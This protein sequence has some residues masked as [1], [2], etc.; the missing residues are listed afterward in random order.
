[1]AKYYKI[2]MLITVLSVILLVY[3]FY[4]NQQFKNN[5]LSSDIISKID[6]KKTRL[7]TLIYNKYGVDINI[8]IKITDEI[9]NNLFGLASYSLDKKINIYLNKK[10]FQENEEYMIDYVL[11]HEYAHGIMFYFGYI[12]EA[13]GGHT[14]KWQDIC[15]A[16]E[17]KKCDRYVSHN[18]ILIEKVRF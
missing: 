12:K 9:G 6:K 13:N 1:M 18:D 17:G 15:L 5:P 3:I 2:F 4:S 7:R 16:L 10:R 11:P 14:K 8:P